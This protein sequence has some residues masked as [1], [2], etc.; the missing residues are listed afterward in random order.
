MIRKQLRRL[1]ALGVLGCG[2]GTALAQ[3]PVVNGADTAWLLTATALV[4]F[5]TLPGPG[6]VL[7]RAGARQERAVGADAVLRDHRAWC[8]CCGWLAG[9]SLA[10]GDGGAAQALHRRTRQ[11]VPRRASTRQSVYA[12]P[13]P[14]SVFVMFQMTFAIITPALVIGAFAERMRF[15]A[16]LCSPRCGCCWC[17][18][19]WRTGSGAAAGWRSWACS[20]SPAASWC[21]STPA[22]R[23]W[24]RA[25]ARATPRLSARPMPPH[26]LPLTVAGAGMLWVG[27][28]GFNAGSALAANGSAGMA[29]L[30]THTGRRGRLR[31]P[32]CC[33]SGGARQ[34]Q[35]ARHRHR[36][37]R[38][39]RHHHAGLGL[40]RPGGRAGHRP[41]GRHRV[42]LARR[43]C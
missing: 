5:M 25:G 28:F 30:V 16:M 6:A 3:V 31:S 12:A 43:S 39:A 23:R 38:G 8:R 18:C 26:N 11:G 10:F 40:R 35:R 27:W 7:R 17:T 9:Y 14:E 2:C 34:A 13:I 32:G 33:W 29:M 20:T 4:L 24:W 1:A 42:L 21:T 37:G 36:H 19:R 41:R 15:S 22:S